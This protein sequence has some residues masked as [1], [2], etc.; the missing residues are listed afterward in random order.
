[1]TINIK[2]LADIEIAGIDMNDYPK[3]CDAYV[4]YAEKADGTPLTDAEIDALNECED[5]HVYVNEHAYSSLF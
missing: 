3:F 4:E 1:M 2:D 5:T